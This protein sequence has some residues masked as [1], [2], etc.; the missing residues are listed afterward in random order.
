MSDEDTIDGYL[1]ELAD[2]GALKKARVR[3]L[4]QEQVTQQF[5]AEARRLQIREK[6]SL[7]KTWGMIV[8]CTLGFTVFTTLL[9]IYVWYAEPPLPE[10]VSYMIET[11]HIPP[12]HID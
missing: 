12:Q 4:V 10:V 7:R 1:E 6:A 9:M 8:S 2:G 5:E 3:T 11:M